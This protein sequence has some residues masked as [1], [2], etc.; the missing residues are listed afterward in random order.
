MQYVGDTEIMPLLDILPD[1][2]TR[3]CTA[4]LVVRT[5]VVILE[6]FHLIR[7]YVV[8]EGVTCNLAN[9]NVWKIMGEEF[10]EES[11][12]VSPFHRR[13]LEGPSVQR[14]QR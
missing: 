1:L 5:Q 8:C 13:R 10:E 11:S 6:G 7:Y 4:S 12:P 14:G 3:A 9:L 2:S